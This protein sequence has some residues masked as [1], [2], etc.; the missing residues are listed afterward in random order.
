MA[1]CSSKFK[2][3]ARHRKSEILGDNGDIHLLRKGR[4][5]LGTKQTETGSELSAS[6]TVVSSSVSVKLIV[7][8]RDVKTS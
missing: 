7:S 8:N 3:L 5:L 2:W 4:F 1:A 6:G